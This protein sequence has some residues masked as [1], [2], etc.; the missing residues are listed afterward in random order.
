MKPAPFEY[1]QPRELVEVY[2]HLSLIGDDAKIIAGGQSLTPM[3]SMRL[4]RPALLIDINEVEALHGNTREHD[5]LIIRAGSRQ[6]SLEESISISKYCPLLKKALPHIGHLQTR[7]RGTFG[8]SVVHADPAAEIPLIVTTLEGDIQ[9]S[10]LKSERLISADDFFVSA[11][12]TAIQPEECLILVKLPVWENDFLGTSFQEVS[13]RKGDFALISVAT[14]LRLD[15]KGICQRATVG[16]SGI[17]QKPQRLVRLA[18]AL[19]GNDL[20]TDFIKRI[21]ADSIDL[22]STED[23][24]HATADYRKR[25]APYLITK[26]ILDATAD[27][28]TKILIEES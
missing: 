27:A 9:L 7:N 24:L 21:T 28:K 25:V 4:V 17:G 16:I 11:L 5:Q 19:V 22:S 23:D 1:V 26:T 12:T 18:A 20:T 14:Q 2:N 6:R 10:S 8:G 13:I 3:M 15:S